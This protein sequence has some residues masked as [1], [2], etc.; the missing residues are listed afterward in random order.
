MKIK[1]NNQFRPVL[2]WQDLEANEQ[3]ELSDS[4]DTVQESTFFRYRG[5]VYDIGEFM[6][7]QSPLLSAWDGVFG[8]SY[9]SA[10]LVKYSD[11]GDAVKV[12]LA[13]S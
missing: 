13:L 3:S 1:T 8:T 7:T 10:V 12:G 6:I 9:F 11:D 4:H 2:Y 5:Q